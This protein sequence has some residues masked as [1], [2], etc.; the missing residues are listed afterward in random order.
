MLN[1]W[2]QLW[3]FTPRWTKHFF[4]C[5]QTTL[6]GSRSRSKYFYSFFFYFF[7]SSFLIWGPFC[8]PLICDVGILNKD[9]YYS[10]ILIIKKFG[11]H[12]LWISPRIIN[13]LRSYIFRVSLKNSACA[14]H[15]SV[16]GYQMKH[17]FDVLL[18]KCRLRTETIEH[19]P[20]WFVCYIVMCTRIP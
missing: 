12:L 14:T 8:K 3:V 6:C 7:S 10:V 11:E 4:Q 19:S 13:A 1:F 15:F 9:C 17:V 5:K 2:R 20:S 16:F 18:L